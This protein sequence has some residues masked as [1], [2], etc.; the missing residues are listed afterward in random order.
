MPGLPFYIFL[1]SFISKSQLIISIIK[2]VLQSFIL[3]YFLKKLINESQKHR[4]MVNMFFLILCFFPNIIKHMSQISYEEGFIY[5][6]LIILFFYLFTL[7]KKNIQHSLLIILFFSFVVFLFKS[8]MIIFFLTT[9]LFVCYISVK[10]NVKIFRNL[11]TYLIISLMIIILGI[12]LNHNVQHRDKFTLMTSWEGANF[13]RGAN[14]EGYRIYPEY[15]LDLIMSG[16]HNIKLKNNKIVKIPYNKRRDEFKNEDLWSDYYKEKGVLWIKNN[17]LKFLDYTKNKIYNFFVST[18]F[19]P[20]NNSI[21]NDIST[22]RNIFLVYS[23][24][25]LIIG[26][27]MCLFFIFFIVK[28]YKRNIDIILFTIGLLGSYSLPY[29]VG[30]NYERHITGFLILIL[31]SL[32]YFSN[33]S[34]KMELEK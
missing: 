3:F 28:F 7:Q 30:F 26:R 33:T 16:P 15:N 32:I 12:W 34:K 31:I 17:P 4:K 9:I 8:S 27:L 5:E 6:Y 29:I 11:N 14:E 1:L 19:S 22:F 24:V 23:K 2:N 20:S 18:D 25:W 13:F 21:I 10:L